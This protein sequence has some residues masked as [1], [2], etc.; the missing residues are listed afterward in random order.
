MVNFARFLKRVIIVVIFIPSSII[1]FFLGGIDAVLGT[2]LYSAFIGFMERNL[3]NKL[4]ELEYRTHK[5]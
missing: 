1:V 4:E 2:K 3:F 5:R